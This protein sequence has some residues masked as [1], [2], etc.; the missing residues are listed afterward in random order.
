MAMMITDGLIIASLVL[1]FIMLCIALAY[2]VYQFNKDVLEQRRKNVH[3]I[4]IEKRMEYIQAYN[5]GY[6]K[7]RHDAIN[8]LT[9]KK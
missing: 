5:E 6:Y 7:G 2:C 4:R 1:V 3:R 9:K 8:S